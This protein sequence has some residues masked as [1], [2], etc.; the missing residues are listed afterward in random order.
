MT[1]KR[2]KSGIKSP[3]DNK[4]PA[5]VNARIEAGC[6][7]D[8]VHPTKIRSDLPRGTLVCCCH[9]T[10]DGSPGNLFS[11]LDMVVMS[12]V[13]CPG[14]RVAAGVAMIGHAR[15][16]LS[17]ALD[18][19]DHVRVRI[20]AELQAQGGFCRASRSASDGRVSS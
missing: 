17:L 14:L 3:G 15:R 2:Q 10:I 4:P 6:R 12:P 13:R 20:A 16:C 8:A 5:K 1:T 7:I 18:D 11:L 9:A 19:R